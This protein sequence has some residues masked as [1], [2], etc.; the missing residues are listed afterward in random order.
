MLPAAVPGRVA[1][2]LGRALALL[3][4]VGGLAVMMREVLLDPAG[5]SVGD[6]G[7]GLVLLATLEHWWRVLEGI[8]VGGTWR[9]A[10]FFYPVA[11]PI[12][13]TDS[14][15]A[16]AI[17]YCLFRFCR[18]GPFAAFSAVM[19]VFAA[20]GY[21]GAYAF[22]RASVRANRAGA[23]LAAW[24]FAFGSVTLALA[25]HAQT[26]TIM[27]AP[28]VGL[29]LRA[30]WRRRGALARGGWGLLAG[31]VYGLILLSAPQTA[32]FATFVGGLVMVFTLLLRAPALLD[33]VRKAALSAV[34]QAG[35][36]VAG[37]LIGL[38]ATVFV[39]QPGR[40]TVQQRPLNE[41]YYYAPDFT[42]VVH[43]PLVE[44]FW[45]DVAG[46]AGVLADPSRPVIE[47]SLGYAPLLLI[48]LLLG[49][50]LT[51]VRRRPPPYRWVDAII[52]ACI[53]AP[54][55]CWLLQVRFASVWLWR[56]VVTWVPAAALIR[57]PFR[58][59][60]A[61]VMVALLALAGLFTR[62]TAR[63]LR[64][65][66]AL[67]A[68][69]FV[70][71]LA[72][73]LSIGLDARSTA[74]VT[75]WFAQVGTPPTACRSFYVAPGAGPRRLWFEYQSEAMMLA[76]VVGL[77]TLNGNS[78]WYPPGWDVMRDTTAPGYLAGVAQW[79]A[80]NRLQ[81]VCRLDASSAQWSLE[82]GAPPS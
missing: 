81:H 57:T 24:I 69:L 16:L 60:D 19:A 50:L 2:G 23:I 75:A 28:L 59:Q 74:D 67:A 53:A 20:I 82:P 25:H 76:Q 52:L 30:A 42:D 72:E 18:V 65:R 27:L 70:L 40:G 4:F 11:N 48:I 54:L 71:L 41:I 77:P 61:C 78:S 63:P 64:W 79:I 8:P 32:W 43:Q 51:V 1:S 39:S 7:D 38:A 45:N 49:A 13:L 66:T 73:Q 36:F 21:G 22:C 3:L 35:G 33:I 6:T 29:C 12:G 26:Y 68:T 14:Y 17:P 31:L 58:I 62:L 9:Q 80:K 44:W 34:P 10:G 5:R 37:A 47:I 15:I 55:L 56:Y 46:R